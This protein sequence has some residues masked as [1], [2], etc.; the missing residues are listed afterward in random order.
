MIW[1]FYFLQSHFVTSAPLTL[2]A[3]VT[4]SERQSPLTQFPAKLSTYVFLAFFLDCLNFEDDSD[5]LSRNVGNYQSTLRNIPEERRFKKCILTLKAQG[6][7]RDLPPPPNSYC[8]VYLLVPWATWWWPTYKAETCSCCIFR[9]VAYYIVILYDKL[10]CFWL[11]VYVNT[12]IIIYIV[13]LT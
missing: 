11:H 2:S 8:I 10:L 4:F 9:S 7:R 5:R 12:H 1:N 6:G 13:L 3:S